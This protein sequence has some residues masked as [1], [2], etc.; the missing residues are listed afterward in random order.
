MKKYVLLLGLVLFSSNAHSQ[1][2][3]LVLLFGDRVATDNFYFSLKA[4]GNWANIDGMENTDYHRGFNFGLITTIKINDRFYIAP[5]F[6]P[7]SPKGAKNIPLALTGDPEIDDILEFVTDSERALNYIDIPVVARYYVHERVGVGCGPQLSILTSAEDIYTADL[8][9]D[10]IVG[11]QRD[12][13][14]EMNLFEFGLVADITYT[15]WKA[16][17]GKGLNFHLRYALG[18]TDTVKDNPSTAL[19]NSY[20]QVSVSFPFVN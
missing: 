4:G 12:I 5:E 3:L 19:T 15:A 14:D 10:Q 1:A 2:A 7:L 18:L 20:I 6:L 17:R 11:Y 16:R 9:G 13:K 8:S